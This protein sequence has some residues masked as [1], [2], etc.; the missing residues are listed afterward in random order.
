[1][2]RVVT[3]VPEAGL[4]A[5]PAARFVETAGEYDAAVR[6]GSA[7]AGDDGLVNAASMLAVT[8]LNVRA[9][10]DVLIVAEGDDAE[11]ALDALETVLST[12]EPGDDESDDA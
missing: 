12:P 4:H 10:E 5:R 11:P 8:G 7:E 3:V 9:G 1:M 6:V 2:R